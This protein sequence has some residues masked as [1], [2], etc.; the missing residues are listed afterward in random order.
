MSFWLL[1]RRSL[2][3]HVRAHLGVVL[4]AAIGSA[5]LIG[6][7]IVGDSVRGSLRERALSRL[8][9][10]DFA[11][12][13]GDRFF[14]ERLAGEVQAEGAQTRDASKPA[15]VKDGNFSSVEVAAL[16]LQGTVSRQDGSARANQVNILGVDLSEW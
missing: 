10:I 12:S 3:F 7:L 14:R 16:Q 2:R 11:M 5:A 4:G 13:P 9:A 15:L 8:G 6:A 1:I